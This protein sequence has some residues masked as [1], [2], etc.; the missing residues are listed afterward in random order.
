MRERE[1]WELLEEV[2][3]RV[4]GRSLSRDQRL[5]RLGG[6][7]VVEALEAGEEPRTIWNVLCDQMEVPDGERWGRDH[8]APPMPYASGR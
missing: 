4:Y 8:N 2:F 3:G 1:F 5:D 7:T 6:M